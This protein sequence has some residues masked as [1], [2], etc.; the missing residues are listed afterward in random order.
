MRTVKRESFIKKSV[1]QMGAGGG[2]GWR[3][4]GRHADAATPRARRARSASA[5]HQHAAAARHQ[6]AVS[7]P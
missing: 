5:R 4:G 3:G 2:L 1:R 7:P 6:A